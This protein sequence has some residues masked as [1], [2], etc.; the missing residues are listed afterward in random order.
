[1]ESDVQPSTEASSIL[2]FESDF[3]ASHFLGHGM[4]EWTATQVHKKM[5][6]RQ[7]H[8]MFQMVQQCVRSMQE[9][10]SNEQL[11][12]TYQEIWESQAMS[13]NPR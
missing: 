12:I 13:Y 2:I 7:L 8:T 4:L 5:I 9:F 3:F 6:I 11:L 10:G 1:M